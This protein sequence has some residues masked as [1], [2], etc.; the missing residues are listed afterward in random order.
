MLLCYR[1]REQLNIKD[2]RTFIT[3]KYCTVSWHTDCLIQRTTVPNTLD[4]RCPQHQE[5][6]HTT[7]QRIKGRDGKTVKIQSVSDDISFHEAEHIVKYGG[8]VYGVSTCYIEHEFLDYAAKKRRR[9]IALDRTVKSTEEW[10]KS[11]P[12]DFSIDKTREQQQGVQMLLEAAHHVNRV[13]QQ[14]LI[15]LDQDEYKRMK[16]ID[17]LIQSKGGEDKLLEMLNKK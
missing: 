4:W 7:K 1:C 8:I 17:Q 13:K 11:L 2:K 12:I 14:P 3:C 15:Q 9:A 16:A 10:V 5:R 6:T